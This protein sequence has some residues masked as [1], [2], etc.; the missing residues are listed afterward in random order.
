M[1]KIPEIA[2]DE[3]TI[4]QKHAAGYDYQ[5]CIRGLWSVHNVIKK[6][7]IDNPDSEKALEC[8]YFL[9][10]HAV[11]DDSALSLVYNGKTNKKYKRGLPSAKYLFQLEKYGFAFTNIQT[12]QKDTP[13]S[14]LAVKNIEQITLSYVLEDVSDCIF[15]LKLFCSICVEQSGDC[16]YS[17]DIRVA[18]ANAPKLYAPPVDEVFYFLPQEQKRVAYA[19]HEQLEALGCIRNLE[20]TYMT[21]YMHPQKKGEAFATIYAAEDLYFLP[22][23][24]KWQKLIFKFNLR[25]IGKYSDYLAQCTDLVRQSIVETMDCYACKKACGG[26]RFALDGVQ[27]AKCPFYAFRFDDLSEASVENYMQLLNLEIEQK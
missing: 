11:L 20:R 5:R 25:N 6:I 27:Y 2:F 15:G 19:I 9:G 4:A 14:K 12:P 7:S 18:F 23:A 8:L 16:F 21:K 22:E 26:V 17:A 13:K 10:V 1:P 3:I 24:E